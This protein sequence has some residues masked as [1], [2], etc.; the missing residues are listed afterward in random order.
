[1]FVSAGFSIP[2]MDTILQVYTLE[3]FSKL[4]YTYDSS[5]ALYKTTLEKNSL[6]KLFINHETSILVLAYTVKNPLKNI[7]YR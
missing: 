7:H 5:Y 6:I 3:P 1:M 2:T 4:G